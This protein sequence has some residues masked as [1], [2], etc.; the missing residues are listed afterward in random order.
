MMQA[1]SCCGWQKG[2]SLDKASLNSE[3]IKPVVIAIIELR[4]FEGIREGE[5]EPVNRK[6]D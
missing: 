5:S 6:F 3:E 1:W 2:T 4:L